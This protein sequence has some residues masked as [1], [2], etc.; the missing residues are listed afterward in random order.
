MP[1]RFLKRPLILLSLAT[2]LVAGCSPNTNGSVPS[3]F[4]FTMD[5]KSAGDF[6]GCAVNV[7]IR[8]DA[9]GGGKYETYDTDCAIVYDTNHIVTYKR[10]QIIEKGK[11]KLSD[12]E[13]KGLWDAINQN[14]FFTLTEDYRMAMGFSYAFILIEADGGRHVVDN[15]GMEVPEVRAIV[16]ATDAIM[17]E[18][19]ELDYGEGFLP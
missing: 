16:E 1:T 5:V 13:L 19:I 10:E 12:T 8:I 18:G 11:F 17:P 14:N 7:N 2:A 3:D 9:K 6:E 15:I 4:L